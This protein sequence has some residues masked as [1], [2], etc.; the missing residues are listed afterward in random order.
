MLLSGLHS[1]DTNFGNARAITNT[2][3]QREKLFTINTCPRVVNLARP[4]NNGP[5]RSSFLVTERLP[6]PPGTFQTS[7]P[8]VAASDKTARTSAQPQHFSRDT[9]SKRSSDSQLQSCYRRN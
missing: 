7:S 6:P 8:P 5:G 9:K 2:L 4:G 1:K 3:T